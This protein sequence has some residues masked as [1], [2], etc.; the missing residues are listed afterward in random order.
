MQC[1]NG[2]QAHIPQF[3]LARRLANAPG[4]RAKVPRPNVLIELRALELSIRGQKVLRGVNL[5]LPSAEIYGL[6]GPNGAGKSTTISVLCGL[7]PASAGQAFVLNLDAW[8]RRLDTHRQMGVLPEQSGFYDWM[9][10][11]EYLQWFARL[12]GQEAQSLASLKPLERVGLDASDP[13]PIATYSRGMRQRLGLARALLNNP[14]LL[15]L[16]EPTNGLDPQGRR[17]IH[18]VLLA[19]NRQGVGILLSTHLLDDVDRL[20]SRIGVIHEGKSVIEGKLAELLVGAQ[21][22]A[23]Y[24]LRV[25]FPP[26]TD[27]LPP[28]VRI[29]ASEGDWWRLDIGE[30]QAPG[31]IWRAL[32]DAGWDIAEIER[33]GGGLEEFYL[34]HTGGELA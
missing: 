14:Q 18:N 24:R 17:E 1:P 29:V 5:T 26:A 30:G 34:R 9:S 15:I 33:E 28:G 3:S 19:L 21:V 31:A 16:D 8:T 25:L 23:R 22:G 2:F 12:Y 32:F 13:R 6:L 11:T 7:R 20:C 27:R 4:S 10:A